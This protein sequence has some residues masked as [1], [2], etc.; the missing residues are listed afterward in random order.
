ML[1]TI[2]SWPLWQTDL[3]SRLWQLLIELA[4]RESNG[5]YWFFHI[6]LQKT[7]FFWLGLNPTNQKYQKIFL[8][9]VQI[10]R[11]LKM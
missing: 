5:P 1:L 8:Y 3:H 4:F 11:L 9:S 7:E 10:F 6:L 2:L